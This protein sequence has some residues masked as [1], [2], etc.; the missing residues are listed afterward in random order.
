MSKQLVLEP[1]MVLIPAG[2]FVMG[3][4]DLQIDRLADQYQ[5]AVEWRQKGYFSRE[6][7]QHNLDLPDYYLGKYPVTVREYRSFVQAGGYHNIFYWTELGWKWRQGKSVEQPTLW[8]DKKWV[9]DD[10]FPV[11]GVSWYEAYAYCCWLSQESGRTYHL[12][13]EAEW[14]KAARGVD[15]RLFPWGNEFDPARCNTRKKGLERT[16]TVG[17][18]SPSGDSPYGCVD[19]S[20]NVSEWTLSRFAPYPY[21]QV[22]KREGAEGE[23]ERVTRGGSWFS[24]ILRA[25]TVSRGMNDPFFRDSDLGF[26]CARTGEQ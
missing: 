22:D 9:G 6:Q 11:V 23:C 26:R 15:G 12:P 25:R 10:Q 7:P 16:T 4:S 17:Q 14:E 8:D 20:G 21:N 2:S 13:S 18:Y 3:T 24:V 5:M 1:E 19:M